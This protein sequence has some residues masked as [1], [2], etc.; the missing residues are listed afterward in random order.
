MFIVTHQTQPTPLL[1]TEADT[2]NPH[3]APSVGQPSLNL[4]A[5]S[6]CAITIRTITQKYNLYRQ[7]EKQHN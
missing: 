7:L 3:S 6:C 1:H 2:S 4:Q 5:S